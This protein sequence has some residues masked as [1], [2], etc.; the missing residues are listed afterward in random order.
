MGEDGKP[1]RSGSSLWFM[2][3]SKDRHMVSEY[4]LSILR[5]DIKVENHFAQLIA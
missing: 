5:H 2:T 3:E 4:W 1:E